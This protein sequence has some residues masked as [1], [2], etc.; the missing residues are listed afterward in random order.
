MGWEADF[1]FYAHNEGNAKKCDIASLI[2]CKEEY[3]PLNKR[4]FCALKTFE[5]GYIWA[6]SNIPFFWKFV[7]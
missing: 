2:K 6:P 7:W 3:V 1:L 4:S 5:I